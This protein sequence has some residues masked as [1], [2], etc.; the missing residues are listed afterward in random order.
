M[1]GLTDRGDD[2][3]S[4]DDEEGEP[5]LADER[6]MLTCFLEPPLNEVPRHSSLPRVRNG[7]HM[8]I[9]EHSNLQKGFL[10]FGP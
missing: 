7:D 5:E 1:L 8:Y 3:H 6:C 4:A 2:D 10:G 9:Q